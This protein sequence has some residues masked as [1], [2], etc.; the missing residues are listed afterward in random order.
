[1]QASRAASGSLVELLDRVLEKGL[2]IHADLVV[3]LA[4]VPLVAV[5][6]RAAIASIE[7]SLRYG[8]MP[9]Q[10]AEPSPGEAHI[11]AVAGGQNDPSHRD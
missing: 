2:V 6:L 7:T 5:N 9:E 11:P 8:M 4:G 10:M 3:S 1:M